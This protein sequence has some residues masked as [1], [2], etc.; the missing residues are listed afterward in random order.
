MTF[1]ISNKLILPENA[2]VWTFAVLAIKGA[3]KTYDSCVLAEEMVKCGIPIIA[4][5]GLGIWWGLRVGVNKNGKPVQ[6]K[7]G[8]PVVV[9]GGQHKDLSI[10]IRQDRNRPIIDEEKLKL[11]V[12]SILEARMSAVL[13]TSEF[14]KG[15]QRRIVAIFVNELYHLN[16]EYGVRHIFIEEADLWCPQ[17]IMG[18][19]LAA[20]AGAIDDLVR[21]GG[22]FNLGCTLITQRSAVLNKD[23]LT[24]ANCLVVLRILHKLDKKAVETWVESM[25]R[26]DDP[27]IKKWY[28]SLRDLKDGE[29]W[30]WH[31]Q[32]PVIFQ[33]LQFRKRET[34]HAT[35]EYFNQPQTKKLKMMDV[36][37]FI[38]KFKNIFEPKPKETKTLSE[39]KKIIKP[40][41]TVIS[42]TTKPQ[43]TNTEFLQSTDLNQEEIKVQQTLPKIVLEKLVP[44]IQ[45]PTEPSTPLGKILVILTNHEGRQDRWTGSKIKALIRRHEWPDSEADE[46][47]NQLIRW[48]ILYRQSNNYLRFYRERVQVTEKQCIVE[49]Q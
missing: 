7:P 33:R 11:M 43:T 34:L 3:G 5:D 31:P 18:P 37:D 20:S 47:I 40:A 27:R 19:E 16:A 44:T 17:K 24:Q 13:D 38:E 29:A 10:P 23:V 12:K 25:A 28:D 42:S 46:A 2:A 32:K 22:N 6:S 30:V 14:S 35:R 1:K 15:M 9:F 26:P 36:T 45:I 41:I 48:E 39:P 4:L 21:R 49:A 8:L